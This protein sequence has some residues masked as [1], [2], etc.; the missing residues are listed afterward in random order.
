MRLFVSVSELKFS[1]RDATCPHHSV[2]W[3]C[4]KNLLG[5]HQFWWKFELHDCFL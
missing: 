1:F 5:E 4:S 3:R 2:G